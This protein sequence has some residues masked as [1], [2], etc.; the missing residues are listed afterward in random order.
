MRRS[1][2][3]LAISALAIAGFFALAPALPLYQPLVDRY[4]SGIVDTATI[5]LGLTGLVFMIIG[6][7]LRKLERLPWKVAL[8]E[9]LEPL[10]MAFGGIIW[11]DVI[12]DISSPVEKIIVTFAFFLALV[13]FLGL[14]R[15]K[16][17]PDRYRRIWITFWIVK[18]RKERF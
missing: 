15:K 14:F 17:D 1:T 11:M 5:I 10:V 8:Y 18:N 3:L 16:L 6:I 13:M 4:G 2:S 7:T 12:Q 9:T